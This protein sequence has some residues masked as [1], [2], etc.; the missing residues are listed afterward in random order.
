MQERLFQWC[1][2]KKRHWLITPNTHIFVW[3]SDLV[4]VTPALFIHEFEIKLTR[5]DFQ[6]DFDKEKHLWLQAPQTTTMRRPNYFW[7]VVPTGLVASDELPPYA[8]LIE[9]QYNTPATIQRAPR[10]HSR[11]MQEDQ[12]RDLE[13]SVNNRYWKLRT[14]Y[15]P[16]ASEA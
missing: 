2:V 8:G 1:A 11:K 9:I 10:I 6:R 12:R 16:A 5:Q 15:A 14:E 4:S 3:E 13:Q 7:Y